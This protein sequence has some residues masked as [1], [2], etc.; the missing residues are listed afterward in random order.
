M[1]R[2]ASNTTQN[3]QAMKQTPNETPNGAPYQQAST[4]IYMLIIPKEV[5]EII[6]LYTDI[7][8]Q[9]ALVCTCTL[10]NRH[11]K[12]LKEK[13][14]CTWLSNVNY[15]DK[16]KCIKQTEHFMSQTGWRT[17]ETKLEIA[18]ISPENSY[19]HHVRALELSDTV[20]IP[21]G[22]NP[23]WLTALVMKFNYGGKYQLNILEEFPNL[24][25]LS[26]SN[27]TFE[28]DDNMTKGFGLHLKAISL[29]NCKCTNN[30]MLRIL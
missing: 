20:E 9:R 22:I 3:Q 27:V 12:L 11:H 1:K 4:C 15:D 24:M 7:I 17:V 8:S 28:N 29:N 18:P 13:Q 30:Q 2:K 5:V 6:A 21:K 19:A 26:L 23:E 16:R 25:L 14:T 10:L